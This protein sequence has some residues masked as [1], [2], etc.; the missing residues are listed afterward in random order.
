MNRSVDC[1]SHPPSQV[2]TIHQPVENCYW[3]IPGRFLAGEYPRNLDEA[4]SRAKINALTA[5]GMT[6][7]IDLTDE[8]EGLLPYSG[9]LE[10]VSHQRFPI[11]DVSIPDSADATVAILNA[12]DYHI[13]RGGIVYLHCWGGVGRTGVI[14]GCWLARHGYQGEAAL[15]RLRELW[16]QCPKSANR[17]SPET[18]EQEQYI[19]NWAEKPSE[20]PE[21]SRA[22]K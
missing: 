13:R 17:N 18:P 5:A 12:I 7:F 2:I 1:H 11:R 16:K 9:F 20:A 22:G 10:G 8:N 6:A 4:S 14:V 3:V 21:G 19:M 15:A